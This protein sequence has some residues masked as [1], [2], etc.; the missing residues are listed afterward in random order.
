MRRPPR[1]LL[2]KIWPALVEHRLADSRGPS[3]VAEGAD[4]TTNACRAVEAITQARIRQA[5]VGALGAIEGVELI[6]HQIC[7]GVLVP[8][9]NGMVVAQKALQHGGWMRRLVELLVMVSRMSGGALWQ[10][11]CR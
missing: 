7:A 6:H 2:E 11:F 5:A 1:K 10:A 9:G 3:R 4:S 8:I